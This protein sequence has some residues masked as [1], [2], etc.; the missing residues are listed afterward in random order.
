MKNN[1]KKKLRGI[2]A[3][4]FDGDGVLFSGRVLIDAEKG[5][6][7]KERSHIDGQGISLLREAGIKIVFVSGEKTGF[8]E[9]IGEKLNS[10]PSVNSGKWPK[11]SI[12]SGFQK[13]EKI[14]AV[15]NWL[16]SNDMDWQE[17]AA[18]G[19]DLAD[20]D[21]LKRVGFSAAPNQAEMIIKEIADYIAPRKGG[22]GAIRDLCNLILE[23]KNI[24]SRTLGLR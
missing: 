2:K 15:E 22:D 4:I 20:Y 23:A 6:V 12:F 3:V 10:L 14:K 5:E 9:K 16:K 8:I 21:I 19:D 17:C 7:S 1:L 13:E 18:M 24:D 11:I